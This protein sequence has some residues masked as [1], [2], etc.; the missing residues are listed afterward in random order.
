MRVVGVEMLAGMLTVSSSFREAVAQGVPLQ[1]DLSNDGSLLVCGST[2]ALQ[3]LRTGDGS[4]VHTHPEPGKYGVT[5]VGFVNDD[6][7]FLVRDKDEW[8]CELK[9]IPVGGGDVEVLAS[10]PYGTGVHSIARSRDGHTFAVL[11]TMVEIW[12]D[13]Q[14]LRTIPG[15]SG[16]N[17]VQAAFSADGE[18]IYVHGTVENTV[19]SY[20]IASGEER[21]RWAAAAGYG[22]Q[23]LV[24]PDERFLV[25]TAGMCVAIHDLV[26]GERIWHDTDELHKFDWGTDWGTWVTAPDSSMVAALHVSMYCFQLPMFEQRG[27]NRLVV[28]I[29]T[30]VPAGAWA[31]AA[32]LVAFG[33][34]TGQILWFGLTPRDTPAVRVDTVTF[35]DELDFE[36]LAH[37]VL[38]G[39]G[40]YGSLPSDNHPLDWIERAYQQVEQTPYAARLAHGVAQCLTAPDPLVRSQALIFFQAHRHAAC[41]N[42]IATLLA[43]DRTLF[44][45]VP[46][47]IHPGTD[48][49]WQLLAAL[50][51][52]ITAYD[53]HASELAMDEVLKPG[54]AEPLIAALCTQ[55]PE[56]VIENAE[57]ITA[58]T[59]KAGA[60]LLIQLADGSHDMLDLARRVA[61]LSRSD[62]RFVDDITRFVDSPPVRQAILAAHAD[63][64][65]PASPPPEPEPERDELGLPMA[66]RKATEDRARELLLGGFHTRVEV[67]DRIF[68]ISGPEDERVSMEQALAI[69][70]VV[71]HERLTEQ[72]DWP[73]VTDADRVL[74]VFETLT[75]NGITARAN[76]TCCN[77]CGFGEIRGEAAEDARGFVFFHEQDALNLAKGRLYLSYGGFDDTDSAVV[78]R[79]VVEALA[80]AGLPVEWDGSAN[81]RIAVTPLDWKKR[82]P[83]VSSP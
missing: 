20:D 65:L 4:V 42:R 54:K 47:P 78:G 22:D 29:G 32:P 79:E 59:P 70:D 10:Y 66:V 74:S 77:S 30:R 27:D 57:R 45:G 48:L 40:G 75:A 44:A 56:W 80:A 61:P 41:G 5:G 25:N 72:A 2:E 49:E 67:A 64:T 15:A 8:T 33:T 81:S 1:I 13:G 26:R 18:R 7:V 17:P 68:V 36:A 35:D 34:G 24:T 11:G 83:E 9:R 3:V 38:S 63:E 23:V 28:E 50:G 43:G 46:D 19:V 60:T 52:R 58:A 76:F 37:D 39:G 12:V 55:K 16:F 14:V 73:A 21:G 69:V 62:P 71:W 82:L 51:A 31:W 6:V 53:R